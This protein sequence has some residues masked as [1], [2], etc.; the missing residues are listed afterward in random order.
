MTPPKIILA[1]EKK[2]RARPLPQAPDVG[3]YLLGAVGVG[4]A[5]VGSADLALVWYPPNFGN[6]EFEFGSV[7]S[8]LNNLPIVVLGLTMWLGSGAA[9][10]QRWVVRLASLLLLLL[11]VAIA[12]G[13]VLYLTDVPLALRAEVEPLVLIGIKKS[14]AKTLVQAAVYCLVLTYVAVR[15]L[16]HTFAPQTEVP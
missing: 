16:R 6:A 3:W 15:G 9:R 13:T 11:T 14:I 4:F 2:S 12:M 8:A 7:T 1:E 10:G 5:V